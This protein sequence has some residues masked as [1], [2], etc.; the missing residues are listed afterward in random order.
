MKALVLTSGEK[1]HAYFAQTIAR[2]F[3]L[4]GI[5]KESKGVY[6]SR[7]EEKSSV[8]KA[9]FAALKKYSSLWFECAKWPVVP[10]LELDK[11]A[12]N[13]P[14]INQ[15]AKETDADYVFLFGTS[16]LDEAWLSLFPQRIINLHLGLSP[17]Y[18]GSATLFWPIANNQIECVGTTIHLAE[19]RVDSGRILGQIKPE[20]NAGDNYYDINFK[21][22]KYSIDAIPDLAQK[23]AKGQLEPKIQDLSFGTIYRKADF[24]EEA[25]LKALD[26]IGEGLSQQQINKIRVSDKCAC[27]L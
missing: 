5:I 8:V 19:K 23:Y 4:V 13:T 21:A 17:Y 24:N 6:Y 26:V 15:W 25:L 9:H 3:D 7:E 14:E 20:L 22:I 2:S 11:G 16:I 1:R 12:I 27:L 10:T 18:R